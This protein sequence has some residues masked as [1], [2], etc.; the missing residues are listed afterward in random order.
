MTNPSSL[1]RGGYIRPMT[2]GVQLKK[3]NL[4][5]SLKELGAKTN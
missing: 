2:A 4:A 3:I 1:Q 5:V